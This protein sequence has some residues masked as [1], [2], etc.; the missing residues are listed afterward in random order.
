[1]IIRSSN[2]HPCTS[3]LGRLQQSFLTCHSTFFCRAP[4]CYPAYF[5]LL[6]FVTF[7]FRFPSSEL[8]WAEL[9]NQKH[10]VQRN[11]HRHSQIQTHKVQFFNID[12]QPVKPFR[13]IPFTRYQELEHIK[14]I[15]K[16]DVYIQ[17]I[18]RNFYF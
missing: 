16:Q 18:W 5:S 9:R 15:T 12:K 7:H 3:W 6:N 11:R 14:Y 1:M 17:H 13:P 2:P 10:G 4:H 8:S